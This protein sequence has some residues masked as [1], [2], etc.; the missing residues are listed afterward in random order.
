MTEPRI[1]KQKHKIRATGLATLL[2]T[3]S[4][5]SSLLSSLNI[6]FGRRCTTRVK[7]FRCVLGMCEL[8][9]SVLYFRGWLRCLRLKA[10]NYFLR[11]LVRTAG[12]SLLMRN[13]S[14][15]NVFLIYLMHDHGVLLDIFFGSWQLRAKILSNS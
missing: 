1:Q 11:G 9:S 3:T 13:V 10:C 2:L 12:N 5:K 6:I 4:L 15:L 8:C 14:K 7:F